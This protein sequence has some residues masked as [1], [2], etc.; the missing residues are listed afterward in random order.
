MPAIIASAPGK[1]IL[2][3]EHAAVYHR[4]AIAV[5]VTQVKAKA[6]I[7]PAIKLAPGTVK[8]E[9]PDIQLSTSLD[10]L[11]GDHPLALAIHSV[12]RQL[13]IERPPAMILQVNSTIPIAAGLGSGAAVSVAIIRALSS[14]LGSPLP[15]DVISALAYEVE[16][17]H[18]GNPS[19]IDNTVITFARPVY[20]IRGQ[21]PQLFEVSRPFTLVIADTGVQSPTA[22]VVNGVRERWQKDTQPYE[23]WFDQIGAIADQAR[24]VIEEGYPQQLGSLMD[25]N[26][27]LL[28]EIGVSSPEL[29]TLVAAARRAGALGAKL[30]GGGAGGN[31]IALTTPNNAAGIAS[32][33]EQAGATR[34]LITHLDP[35]NLRA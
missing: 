17:I 12:F 34:T 13:A 7:F 35:G 14:F 22:L 15:D 23:R 19:G 10:Q 8:I 27:A 31:M 3:G 30:S 25:E 1:I 20:F 21:I 16:R 4:P 11:G 32:Q 24:K 9:A 33:L 28:E 5:P 2:F 6:S 18:H 26:Q 29:E